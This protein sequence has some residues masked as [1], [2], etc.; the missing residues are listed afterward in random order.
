MRILFA[1]ENAL[2]NAEADAEVFTA[3]ARYLAQLVDGASLHVPFARRA[4][5]APIAAVAGLAVLRA[6]APLRPAALRHLACGSTI[7]LRR[8]FR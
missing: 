1:F 4:D 6:W 5:P 8:A 2:P 3:T 7:V